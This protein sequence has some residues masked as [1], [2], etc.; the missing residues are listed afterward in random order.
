MGYQDYPHLIGTLFFRKS[1]T[2][3]SGLFC[4]GTAVTLKSIF[5]S[6][7]LASKLKVMP[8]QPK[9]AP[10]R[11]ALFKLAFLR[12]ALVNFAPDKLAPSRLAPCKLTPFKLALLKLH[13]GHCLVCSNSLT[14]F[15]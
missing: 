2:A 15:C 10:V 6:F 9:S 4:S 3:F 7:S 12:L 11:L 1:P 8:A 14:W 13:S 5:A